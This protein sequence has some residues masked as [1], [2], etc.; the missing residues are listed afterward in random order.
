MSFTLAIQEVARH[1]PVLKVSTWSHILYGISALIKIL[2]GVD[3][4]NIKTLKQI[5]TSELKY[6]IIR[7]HLPLFLYSLFR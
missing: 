5:F 2:V 7:Q 6:I 1:V 4:Y 3:I